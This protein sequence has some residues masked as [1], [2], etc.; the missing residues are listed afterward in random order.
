MRIP[1]IVA[2]I[3]PQ[4]FCRLSNPDNG[5]SDAER[6]PWVRRCGWTPWVLPGLIFAK[7]IGAQEGE[8]RYRDA[9]DS[10]EKGHL[11]LHELSLL[12]E[13]GRR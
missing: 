6:H 11:R 9:S 7:F 1:R 8:D 13:K 12:D 3:E 5:L 4:D 10:T 2:E